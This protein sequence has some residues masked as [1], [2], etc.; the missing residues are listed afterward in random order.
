MGTPGADR[1]RR[2]LDSNSFKLL[3]ETELL[4]TCGQRR[5]RFC[6]PTIEAMRSLALWVRTFLFAGLFCACL[7]AQEWKTATTL[8]GIDMSGLSQSQQSTVLKVL[9]EHDCSCQCGRKIAQCRVEDPGCSYSVGLAV[10]VVRSI[11]AGNSEE[12]AWADASATKWAQIQSNDKLL[13]NAV[14]IPVAG[15]PSLG[16]ANAP[17]TL[18]EFSDFQCPYCAAAV[19]EIKALLKA[20]PTQVKLIFK[21]FPLET[22]S[23]ADLAAAAALAAQ[24]QGKFWELHDAMYSHYQELTRKNILA[25]AKQIGLDMDRFETDLDSTEVRETV[26][27]DVQDGD[28][29]GVQ[30]TPTLF[31]DGQRYN[32]PLVLSS[33]KTVVDDELKNPPAATV[34]APAAASK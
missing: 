14:S 32:G 6:T 22:H 12:Q 25:L 34:A 30:G 8:P 18:I 26:V 1:A 15:A 16:P 28:D 23:Q 7:F 3:V 5:V 21:Q 4:L 11:K 27:R 20:Y 17:I 24:K 29:A 19:P 31:V 9:R 2:F 10:A 33:M 13:S